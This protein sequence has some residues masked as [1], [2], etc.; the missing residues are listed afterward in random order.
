MALFICVTVWYFICMV[1]QREIY[2]TAE[3][4]YINKT[5]F[6]Y[7]LNIFKISKESD[8]RKKKKKELLLTD[9]PSWMPSCLIYLLT[10]THD[11][12]LG[13]WQ[14]SNKWD[15]SGAYTYKKM[16]FALSVLMNDQI[17]L[18]PVLQ[19]WR[20][21]MSAI[22]P[23]IIFALWLHLWLHDSSFHSVALMLTVTLMLTL[24]IQLWHQLHDTNADSMTC[25]L[26]LCDR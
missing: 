24:W 19:S 20:W 23:S 11:T 10:Q 13:L 8:V 18:L 15:I 4:W 21:H 22:S 5:V 3:S 6:C 7:T 2:L 17:F 9:T 12:S 16:H 1:N 14:N 25:A 26:T